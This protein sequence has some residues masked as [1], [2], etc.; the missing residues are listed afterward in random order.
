MARY[1]FLVFLILKISSSEGQISRWTVAF[2]A[3]AGRS[4]IYKNEELDRDTFDEYRRDFSYSGGF[5]IGYKFSKY[6]SV[7]LDPEWEKIEDKRRRSA[8]Q[9]NVETD[10]GTFSFT[11]IYDYRNKFSRLQAP[12]SVQIYP[13]PDKIKAYFTGGIMPSFIYKG[14]ISFDSKTTRPNGTITEGRKFDADFSIP[15]NKGQDKD[16]SYLAGLG[17]SISKRFSAELIYRFNRP[18][19]YTLFDPGYTM[20]AVPV[21][22]IRANQGLQL[23]IIGKLN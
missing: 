6:L 15:Q 20:V 16:L 2:K 19:R 22:T 11:N 10:D 9:R 8:I 4:G 17:F 3:S 14:T 7:S 13:F 21:Y 12:L 5:R 1:A 23:S 18:I